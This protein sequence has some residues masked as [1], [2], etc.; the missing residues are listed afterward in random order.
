MTQRP[1]S[2]TNLGLSL[3]EAKPQLEMLR[4]ML[5]D[6]NIQ[7]DQP[8]GRSTATK[9][10]EIEQCGNDQTGWSDLEAKAGVEK[11]TI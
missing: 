10:V 1:S 9:P 8:K 4:K 6:L 11:S 5:N 3:R 2:I 7:C